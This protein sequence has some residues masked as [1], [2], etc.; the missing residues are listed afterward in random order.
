[1]TIMGRRFGLATFCLLLV[2]ALCFAQQ[3]SAGS[4]NVW[5]GVYTQAQADRGKVTYTALCSQCHGQELDG[6]DEAPQLTGSMF[7]VSWDG[8]PLSELAEAI[9]TKMPASDPGSLKP[10]QVAD[11]L[12]YMLSYNKFPT[13][14]TELPKDSQSMK[15]ITISRTKPPQK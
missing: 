12:A 6:G 3:S 2:S 8:E 15:L 13:G 11:I 7:W 9:Q 4:K 1:M 10:D 14:Q 5:D